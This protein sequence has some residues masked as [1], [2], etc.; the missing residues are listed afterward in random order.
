MGRA[1]HLWRFGHYGVPLLVMPSS[2]GMAHEW[3]YNGLIE[4]LRPLIEGGRLKLYCSESNVSETWGGEGVHPTDQIRRH[5]DF[6]TYIVDELVPMI[7]RDCRSATIRLAVAGTSLGAFYAAN[8]VLRYPELFFYGLCLSGRYDA[9]WLTDGF[10]NDDIY[11]NNPMAF[12]PNL[13]GDELER[14]RSRTHMDLVCGQG[15][16]EGDNIAATQA[17][18]R[19]LGKKGISHVHDLWGHDVTHEP[20]W[21]SL[22]AAHYLTRHFGGD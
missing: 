4:T 10:S 8:L 2:A 19:V 1:M 16:F 17:F 21:W 18:A 13:A 20:K 22:Q 12:V 11:Y 14:V 7:R 15:N 9:T 5:R 6:E 3:E